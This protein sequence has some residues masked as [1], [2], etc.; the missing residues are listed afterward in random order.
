MVTLLAAPRLGSGWL[1]AFRRLALL[2][3][4]ILG[5]A[6]PIYID[7]RNHLLVT[8]VTGF[9]D[10][11][12]HADR[13]NCKFEATAAHFDDPI[14][15]DSIILWSRLDLAVEQIDL[16]K[17]AGAGKYV[18]LQ[19][20]GI[21]RAEFVD[22]QGATVAGEL[23]LRTYSLD[24]I[25]SPQAPVS[26]PRRQS[27]LVWAVPLTNEVWMYIDAVPAPLFLWNIGFHIHWT[28][29]LQ[30]LFIRNGSFFIITLLLLALTALLT[31]RAAVGI[32]RW[33]HGLCAAC[34]YPRHSDVCPEC[35][36]HT[37]APW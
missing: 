11:E 14:G 19:I 28:G 30:F 15:P 33:H 7:C 16:E 37:V 10:M 3:S 35:G 25:Q 22:E 27:G 29:M 6:L 26:S 31:G 2:A 12:L 36:H 13:R 5:L 21:H 9:T 17:H 20:T 1:F 8:N 23:H 18:P 34:G 24:S 4:V 32:W